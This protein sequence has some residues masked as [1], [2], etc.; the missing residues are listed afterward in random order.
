[1]LE[2]EKDTDM[3]GSTIFENVDFI[4]RPAKSNRTE[5]NVHT[6]LC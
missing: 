4:H 5:V 3:F 6:I 2:L 1:M